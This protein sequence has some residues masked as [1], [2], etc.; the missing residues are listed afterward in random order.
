[1]K[2]KIHRWKV[3]FDVSISIPFVIVY[4]LIESVNINNINLIIHW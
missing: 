1:M 3:T 4:F 2:Q